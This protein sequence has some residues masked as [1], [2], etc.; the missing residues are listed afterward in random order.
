MTER[1][2]EIFDIISENPMISQGELSNMLGIARS[3]VAVHIS[4]L[5][6]EG[7]LKGRGYVINQQNHPV[8]IG[9]ANADIY[10][11][12]DSTASDVQQAISRFLSVNLNITYGGIAKNVAESLVR[13]GSAPALISVVG[14]GLLGSEMLR[15]CREA[16]ISTSD[17]LIYGDNTGAYIEVQDPAGKKMFVGL[18]SAKSDAFLSPEVLQAKRALLNSALLILAE[19]SMMV[20]SL[21]YISSSYQKN[22]PMLLCTYP[23]RVDKYR[24]FFNQFSFAIMS[25]EVAC[26]LADVDSAQMMDEKGVLL[27]AQRVAAI[28][29]TKTLIVYGTDRMCLVDQDVVK[30]AE[31]S[32]HSADSDT[33]YDHCRDTIAAAV[34]RCIELNNDSDSLLH[35][36]SAARYLQS[37]TSTFVCKS[38][39][40]QQLVSA[41]KRGKLVVRTLSL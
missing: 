11:R 10:C 18:S 13:L 8:I 19:D 9:A 5:V 26:R 36:A 32:A 33:T 17:I 41:T 4:N 24:E 28:G 22:Y 23:E 3:S 40:M 30:L 2:K 14:S 34:I 21:R 12:V 16:N 20:D 31:F 39:C 15:D 37:Q 38:L 7:V 35:W 1:E 27:V 25:G 6:Q 29:P